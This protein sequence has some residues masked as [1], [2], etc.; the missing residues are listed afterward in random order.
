[1][2]L[3][4]SND[5]IFLHHLQ[6]ET[7]ENEPDNRVRDE[8]QMVYRQEPSADVTSAFLNFVTGGVLC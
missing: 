7:K 3:L 1:M 2:A 4:K 8:I 6:V 5:F